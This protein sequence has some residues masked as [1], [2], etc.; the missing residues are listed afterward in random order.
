V[1]AL[2]QGY[3]SI[4][5]FNASNPELLDLL[6]GIQKQQRARKI[7]QG[8]AQNRLKGLPPPGRAPYGYRRGRDRYIIDRT[9]TPVVRDFF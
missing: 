4:Q 1:I 2:E 8:H 7:R 5:G 6:N 9:I 3:Q